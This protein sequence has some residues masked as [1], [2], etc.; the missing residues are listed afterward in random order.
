[1]RSFARVRSLTSEE[2]LA[3]KKMERSRKLAAGK[4]KRAQVVLL[5]NQGYTREEISERLDMCQHTV[6]RWIIRFNKLG[7]LGLEEGPRGGRPKVYSS[8]DVGIVIE[9]ALTSP[10][11]LGLP[12][13]VWTLDR[14]VAYLSEQ[15][16]IA[17]KRSRISEI[18]LHEGLRWRHQEGWF[19]EKVDP[20]FARKRGLSKHST[21]SPQTTASL[22]A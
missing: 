17:M 12:F 8:E 19:G 11:K 6:S 5:S 3:L 7:I 20:D 13:N 1:M 4:V 15:K 22:S 9:T 14:M 10:Q 21:P 2:Y 18:L 16:S